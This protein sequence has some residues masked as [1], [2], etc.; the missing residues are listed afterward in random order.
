MLSALR[1]NVRLVHRERD[2]CCHGDA[3]VIMLLARKHLEEVDCKQVAQCGGHVD[4]EARFVHF[5]SQRL[6]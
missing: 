2:E 5:L 3:R 6:P 4:D 1:V